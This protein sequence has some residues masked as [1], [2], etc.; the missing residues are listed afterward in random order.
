MPKTRLTGFA[1][2]LIFLIIFLPLA[3]V[4]AS[5]FNGEDPVAT[6]KGWFGT[7]TPAA[8]GPT[9]QPA[10]PTT[11]A[12]TTTFEDVQDLRRELDLTKRELVV[13]REELARCRAE[14]VR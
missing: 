13:A 1:R 12:S 3:F 8:A 10:N 2:L 6:V 9:E 4:A 11:P 5:Y 14:D 7:E